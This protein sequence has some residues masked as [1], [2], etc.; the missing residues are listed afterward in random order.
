MMA[1]LTRQ[2]AA[3]T[4]IAA[5]PEDVELRDAPINPDWIVSGQPVARAGLHSESTAQNT[6]TNIWDCTAGSFWWTFYDEETVVILEGSVHVT[7]DRE[8]RRTLKAGD[9]A[10]FARDSK[11]LWEIDDYVRKI[12]FCRH[13]ASAQVIAL[14]R[15]LGAMKRRALP[16][17]WS[18]P[19]LGT[20]GA[21]LP[22]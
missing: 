6:S 21:M 4:F 10:F 16:L 17:A 8:P 18:G 1:F 12:A 19:V 15:V 11:A 20:I 5:R 14:R 22:I 7:T 9:I 13:P 3:R 2:P